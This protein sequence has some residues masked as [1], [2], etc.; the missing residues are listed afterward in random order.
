MVIL[1]IKEGEAVNFISILMIGIGLSMDA[2]AVSLTMG[3]STN[4]ENKLK[5]AC[6]AGLFFGLFQGLMPLI[7]WLLG[8]KFTQYIQK[9]DHWIAFGLL[10][11][12][13]G[14]MII[15]SLKGN[16]EEDKEVDFSNKRFLILAI[17]T[18]IDALAVGVSFAFLNVNIVFAAIVIACTTFVF[19]FAAV[20]IGRIF[21]EV[22]KSKS[23]IIGGII[24][25][26]MGAKIL[27]QHLLG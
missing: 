16:E 25:V 5:I 18:S 21:G 24:L 9:I 11:F 14:K 23:E 8:I 15:E 19:S 13:G 2:F 6:K 3:M 7:G 26:I 20:Y 10:A 1:L 12:I 22:L 4:K 17:A 27:I